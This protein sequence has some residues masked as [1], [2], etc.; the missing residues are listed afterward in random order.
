MQEKNR[1]IRRSVVLFIIWG[2]SYFILNTMMICIKIDHT[3]NHFHPQFLL[4]LETNFYVLFL[5]IIGYF[6]PLMLFIH[7]RS[8]CDGVKW[9]RIVS[10]MLSI[11]LLVITFLAI[12]VLMG[13]FFLRQ[14]K[15]HRGRFPVLGSVLNLGL[16]G[17]RGQFICPLDFTDRMMKYAEKSGN[18]THSVGYERHE[19][20]GTVL[21][22]RPSED[23]G[24][25]CVF[26]HQDGE[27][28]PVL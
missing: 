25:F 9:L 28:S 22:L 26:A 13:A 7:K 6:L 23:R 27:P 18:N 11:F 19:R 1:K 12:I 14:Q 8:G 21:C 15:Q 17:S 10:K 3:I 4:G 24:R 5:A 2:V 20:Q 16:N